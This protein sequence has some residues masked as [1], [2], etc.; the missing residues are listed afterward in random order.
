MIYSLRILDVA[1]LE[2][3]DVLNWY[4]NIHQKLADDL[5]A[6]IKE[7]MMR[8]LMGPLGYPIASHNVRRALIPHSPYMVMFT[9]IENTIVVIA[10]FHTKRSPSTWQKRLPIH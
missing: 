8:I 9:I 7:T 5:K 6:R 10:I 2:F 3:Q 1:E 4:G